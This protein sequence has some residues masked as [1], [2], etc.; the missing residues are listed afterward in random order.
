MNNFKNAACN[1][2]MVPL[3]I[4]WGCWLAP[5]LGVPFISAVYV[6]KLDEM[7]GLSTVGSDDIIWTTVLGPF[8]IPISLIHAGSKTVDFLRR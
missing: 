1:I 4:V 5:S 7:Q 2:S 3:I 6:A 8:S